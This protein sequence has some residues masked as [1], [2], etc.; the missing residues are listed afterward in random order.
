MGRPIDISDRSNDR[1]GSP[2]S[3]APLLVSFA[4][5]AVLFFSERERMK[6]TCV[7]ALST[8]HSLGAMT[9]CQSV[10]VVSAML[11]LQNESRTTVLCMC[12]LPSG[13]GITKVQLIESATPMF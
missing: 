5:V 2:L 11:A 10:L 3:P 4:V 12:V 13:V 7:R 6:P 1:N 9:I 8:W